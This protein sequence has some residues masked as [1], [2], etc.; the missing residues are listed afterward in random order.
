MTEATWRAQCCLVAKLCLTFCDRMDCSPPGSLSVGFP[1][2][3]TGG[4]CH[5]LLQGI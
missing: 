4:G 3:N 2:K 1:G 5:F